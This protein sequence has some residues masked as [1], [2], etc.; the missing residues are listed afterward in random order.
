MS[1]SPID[2]SPDHH[3]TSLE[4]G[5]SS[6]AHFDVTIPTIVVNSPKEGT[7]THTQGREAINNGKPIIKKE[8]CSFLKL[9]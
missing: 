2:Y 7:A 6:E 4:Y 9:M 8:S 1:S 5:C 3:L